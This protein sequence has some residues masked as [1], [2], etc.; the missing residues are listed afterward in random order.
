MTIESEKPLDVLRDDLYKRPSASL[1]MSARWI[2]ELWPAAYLPDWVRVLAGGNLERW[3]SVVEVA[4]AEIEGEAKDLATIPGLQAQPTTLPA[5]SQ[6][7]QGMVEVALGL[8]LLALLV[9]LFMGFLETPS[10]QLV[11]AGAADAMTQL[12]AAANMHALERHGSAALD[13]ASELSCSGPIDRIQNPTTGRWANTCQVGDKFG[14]L[15][16]ESDGSCVTCFIKDK[17]ANYDQVLRYLANK[18]YVK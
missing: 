18:G 6:R 10:G 11:R 1:I 3:E 17:L 9:L 12:E 7:G 4:K 2:A 8:G 5:G 13:V 15:I 14:V 16:E